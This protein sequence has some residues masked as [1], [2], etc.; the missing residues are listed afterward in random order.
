D[1]L[2][3]SGARKIVTLVNDWTPGLESEAVFK[4]STSPKGKAEVIESLRMPLANPDF[5]PFLQRARD[6]APDTAIRIPGEPVRHLRRAVFG[7]WDEQVWHSPGRYRRSHRRRSTARHDRRRA[8]HRDH[9]PLFG[10][11]RFASE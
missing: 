11:A 3:Q 4:E 5:A 9:P 6:L 10:A 2:V 1:W 8:R 7:A